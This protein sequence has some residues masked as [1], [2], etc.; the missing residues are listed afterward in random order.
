MKKL[1]ILLLLTFVFSVLA[2]SSFAIEECFDH[3]IHLFYSKTC[4]HC[5]NEI[6]FFKELEAQYPELEVMYV[7]VSVSPEKFKEYAKR[8]NT[9]TSGVPRTF[10]GDKVFI[11]FSEE[12]GDLEYHP[13]YKAY[14]GYKNQ[15]HSAI[16]KQ[17]D[18]KNGTLEEK[19]ENPSFFLLLLI[20]LILLI[21]MYFL[22]K[23]DN[24]V[25]RRHWLAAIMGITIIVFFI[26]FINLSTT[27]KNFASSLPF[28]LFVFI[29]AL[30]DGFN[31]CA[32]TV[33]IILLSLL[34]YTKDKKSMLILGLTFILTSAVMYFIFIFIMIV[35]G[36][37]AIQQYGGVIMT[38]LG[39]AILFAG[40]INVKDFFFFKKGVSLSLSDDQKSKFTHKAS[41][42]ARSL[43]EAK[44]LRTFIIALGSTILLA[45]F[46]NIVE[47]G[48]TA[49]LPSIYMVSLVN[50]FGKN[51][52]AYAFWTLFYSIIYILPL[53]AILSNF[54]YTFRSSR[55]TTKQGRI[56][57]L[58]SGAFMI[59]FGILMIFKP[60]LIMFS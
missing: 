56:L 55:L 23:Y 60:E 48:C 38:I 14:I 17:V 35:V 7:E 5:K 31:P 41:K 51:Y 34:T 29:I 16:L 10:I 39:I 12:F 2:Q 24:K 45:I 30:A 20:P 8:Y 57:K 47:L 18:E 50:S 59:L 19:K 37:W 53:V 22:H 40:L 4:P 42:I 25:S 1:S 26:I 21:I 58:I 52:L 27:I 46:V 54:I 15:I 13:S 49:I 28:P 9:T 32:F 11:G 36:D 3:D 33:L 43:K 6:E 44:S